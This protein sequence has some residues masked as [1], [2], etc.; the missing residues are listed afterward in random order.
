FP[1]LESLR[2]AFPNVASNV[3]RHDMAYP[4]MLTFLPTGLLGLV[5]ASLIAAFMS[6]I[7]T[8]L[9]WGSS[10][11]VND[12]YKRFINPQADEKKQV[13]AGR[14]STVGLMIL[15]GL[16][17]LLLSNALQAFQILLQVG[18]GTGLL[19]ILRWFWWRINPYSELT[20][21]GVSFLVAVYLSMIHPHTGLPSIST[22]LQLLLGVGITTVSW[23]SVTLLTSPSDKKTLRSFYRMVK[24]GGPGWK[25]VVEKAR[26]DGEPVEPKEESWDVPQ[27]ILCLVLG[28]FGVYSALFAAGYWIY[29]K[30]T[31]AS[32]LSMSAVVSGFFLVKMWKKLKML[33]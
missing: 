3:I 2:A 26:Q 14:I 7:S 21:M 6:T 31:L 15:T 27:G 18:A 17:A 30:Y 29:G 10:Y 8:H 19:F 5:V 22:H 28:C 9:N 20:A 1:D 13:L 25:K 32:L 16:L 12:F 11:V 33:S 4:A 24:P 23:I